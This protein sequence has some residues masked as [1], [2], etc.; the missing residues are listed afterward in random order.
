MVLSG[1]CY[2]GL[3]KGAGCLEGL[4]KVFGVYLS[5]YG[6]KVLLHDQLCRFRHAITQ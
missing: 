4:G 1:I 6:L 3:V 5:M 2:K